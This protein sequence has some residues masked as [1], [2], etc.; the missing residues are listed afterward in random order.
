MKISISKLKRD[1]K[2]DCLWAKSC[3]LNAYASITTNEKILHKEFKKDIR[4]SYF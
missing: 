3:P 2:I 4:K 1:S